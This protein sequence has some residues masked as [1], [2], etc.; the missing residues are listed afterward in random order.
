M[1][2]FPYRV[3]CPFSSRPGLGTLDSADLN[4]VLGGFEPKSVK[5]LFLH[6]G[7]WSM[8]KSTSK[9]GEYFTCFSNFLELRSKRSW[10]KH[11]SS[12]SI[13][14]LSLTNKPS[15]KSSLFSS[16]PSSPLPSFNRT[17]ICFNTKNTEIQRKTRYIMSFS[18]E[19]IHVYTFTWHK[20]IRWNVFIKLS[21]LSS[22][23][24]IRNTV[25]LLW[26]NITKNPAY[27]R[28]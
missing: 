20:Q 3:G 24:W 26:K 1:W 23:M 11:I 27:G 21:W 28:H 15:A 17:E 7:T 4:M 25:I 5:L 13:N 14:R 18:N 12:S 8:V 19:G 16:S 9:S 6:S 10:Q 2:I 22:I